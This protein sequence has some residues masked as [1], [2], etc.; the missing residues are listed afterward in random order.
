LGY[1][2][3]TNESEIAWTNRA[4]AC[5][6]N[7]SQEMKDAERESEAEVFAVAQYL[8]TGMRVW[9]DGYLM[10]VIV[11]GIQYSDPVAFRKEA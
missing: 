6:H 9:I 10:R 1:C 8:E 5:I 3:K 2:G 4:A 11:N 7:G